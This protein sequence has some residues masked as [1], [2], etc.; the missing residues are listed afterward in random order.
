MA[1]YFFNNLD[2]EVETAIDNVLEEL[3]KLGVVLVTADV[4]NVGT[5]DGAGFPIVFHEAPIVLAEYLGA[6][7][8]AVT[9]T[10][11]I[12][13]VASPDVK[14]VLESILPGGPN[15]TDLAAYNTRSRCAPSCRPTMQSTSRAIMSPR[16]FSP[17]RSFP[18]APSA[19]TRPSN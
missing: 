4:P 2:P 1:S 12:D 11:L 13:Q 17:P 19:R 3:T 10:D 8:P 6:N 18:L 9:L 15:F 5:L 7:D 14:G 16:S